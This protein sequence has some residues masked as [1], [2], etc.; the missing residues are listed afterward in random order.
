M[1][2]WIDGVVV[3]GAEARISVLDHG[4]LYGDGVFEGLRVR[5]GRIFRLDS[6]LERLSVSARTIGLDLPFDLHGLRKIIVETVCA[7]DEADAYVRLIVTRGEGPLGVDPTSC[8]HPRVVCIVD[9]LRLFPEETL[10]RGISLV[11]SSLRRPALDALDPQ[12]KSLNYLNS[13]LAK[14]EARRQGA[15]EALLLNAAGSVA[16]ASV[17]NVFTA[18]G[19]TL[20]TPPAT[21]GALPGI[22]RAAVLELAPRIGLSAEERTLGRVDLFRAEEVF[23]TGTG[24]GIVAVRALDGRPVGTGRAGPIAARVGDA[25]EELARETGTPVRDR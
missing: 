7:H 4:F 9:A 2:V 19:S 23:L 14:L 3:E 12:V 8:A 6:H 24:A 1:K 11:T 18:R 22:T 20:L 13:V 15:D 21:D 16:E 5:A 10:A 25:Y 17:A